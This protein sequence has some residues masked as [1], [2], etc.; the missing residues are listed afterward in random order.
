MSISRIS[1]EQFLF[2][3]AIEDTEQ[4]TLPIVFQYAK[5]LL[6]RG[7]RFF[8]G[9]L[10]FCPPLAHYCLPMVQPLPQFQGGP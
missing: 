9:A 2:Q 8:W 10:V 5:L 4:S 7:A 3:L 6:M 1:E